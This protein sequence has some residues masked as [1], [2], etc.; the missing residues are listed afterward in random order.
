MTR[1]A[2]LGFLVGILTAITPGRSPYAGG[3]AAGRRRDDDPAGA[4]ADV[5]RRRGTN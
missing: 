5:H 1:F 3:A 4:G 2:D